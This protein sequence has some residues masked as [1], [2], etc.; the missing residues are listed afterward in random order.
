[1]S[2]YAIA[3]F[4]AA[5]FVFGLLTY[6]RRHLFGEGPP[7]QQVDPEDGMQ[8]PL[9][10]VMICTCL[11]PILIVSGLHGLWRVYASARR[12]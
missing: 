12:K 4:I 6:N 2:D 7:D 9:F 5:G 1:M 3:L 8:G 10:W 11:W